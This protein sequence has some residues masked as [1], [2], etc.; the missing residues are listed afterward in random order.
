MRPYE[1]IINSTCTTELTIDA[2]SK[3]DARVKITNIINDH[4]L[5]DGPPIDGDEYHTYGPRTGW[6]VKEVEE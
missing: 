1:V 2:R 3:A 4:V 5:F 6:S